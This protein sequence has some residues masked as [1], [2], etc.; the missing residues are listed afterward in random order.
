MPRTTTRQR[1]WES[2]ASGAAYAQVSTKTIRRRILDGSLPAH[3]VG[4]R[5]LR[6]DRADLDKL[7]T[8]VPSDGTDAA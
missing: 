4:P 3:R 8:R 5:L 6:I 1:Q 7:F 2:V